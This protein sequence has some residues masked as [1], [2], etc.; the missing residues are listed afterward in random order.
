MCTRH[1][2]VQSPLHWR[3][4]Q[5]K[6]GTRLPERGLS[7]HQSEMFR[8]ACQHSPKPIEIPDA[9]IRLEGLTGAIHNDITVQS[10]LAV[11]RAD[12]AVLQAQDLLDGVDLSIAIDLGHAGIPY[13]QQFAPAHAVW[14]VQSP[15]NLCLA[16]IAQ[17]LA[18][19]TST[20]GCLG[21]CPATGTDNDQKP[22]FQNPMI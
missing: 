10:S 13:V 7:H 12:F 15:V 17:N 3:V 18:D 22:I 21:T 2:P 16:I 20:H 4:I 5:H 6:A 19:H 11:R 9:V 8:S 14:D 1:R